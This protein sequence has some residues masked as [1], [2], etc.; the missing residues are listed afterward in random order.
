MSRGLRTAILALALI[1]LGASPAPAARTQESIIMDDAHVVYVTPER[2][3]RVFAE[4]KRLGV[5]RVRVSVYWHLIAPAPNQRTRPSF[6]AADPSAYPA[7]H[8]DRY[9]AIV[10]AA[11]KHRL[12]L[13]FTLTGP[14]PLWATKVPERE[15]I[16]QTYDPS[17][18]E[19]RAFVEAV[20][21][22]Y[23]GSWRDEVQAPPPQRTCGLLG[24]TEEQPEAPQGEVLP[25][26]THWS[27]W[28]EPNHPG[29]LTPQ[30]LPDPRNAS[31]PLLPAAARIYRS[32]VDAAWAGLAA[33]GHGG[34]VILLGETAPRGLNDRGLTRAIRPLEFIRELY[35]LDRSLQPHQGEEAQVRGCP[36]TRDA[37]VAQHPG[38]FH[39]SG[40]A[41]HP[42]SLE[43]A[44]TRGDRQ[45][46]NVVLA[47]LGRLTRTLDRIFR[48]HGSS[49]RLPVWLT[50]YGYQTDPP[51]PTIGVSWAR[52][53]AWINAAEYLAYRNRRVASMAQFLLWDDGPLTAYPASDPRYWGTFQ[54]GLKTN[55]GKRKRSYAAYQRPIHVT[56]A[57]ARRGQAIR[58]FGGLRNAD[59]RRVTARL[60]FRRGRRGRYRT[61]RE[62]TVRHPSGYV[63]MRTRARGSGWYRLAWQ[64][65]SR[66]L[67][68]RA[69][70]VRVSGRR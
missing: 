2:L 49:R 46:D 42:Y 48:R 65:G 36:G 70:R 33:S 39:A 12:G 18:G 45:R 50:E 3:D 21:K 37:F 10:R 55:D 26:V 1:A 63:H 56:P 57:Q 38:L 60:Q 59:W 51:D 31:L 25:R 13:L 30:W 54:S 22:R 35:C 32:L 66:T 67:T 19:F 23:S 53:A 8:W 15:D 62:V 9:D 4:F 58:V 34:D 16:A 6:D 20:G 17:P 47:D 43:Q 68:S 64:D 27:I 5:D 24:C 40:W 41:H 29:W 7:S 69:V 14:A 61:L 11:A 52:Q 44:P 28:N